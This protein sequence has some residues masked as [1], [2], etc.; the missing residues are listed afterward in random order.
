MNAHTVVRDNIT[1]IFVELDEAA[2]RAA[3]VNQYDTPVLCV[4]L[5]KSP[6]LSFIVVGSQFSLLPNLLVDRFDLERGTA[7]SIA[8]EALTL[9]AR[10]E[11]E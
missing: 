5:S 3:I 10:P 2:A 1:V 9:V 11:M 8:Q 7:D 6:R 4:L